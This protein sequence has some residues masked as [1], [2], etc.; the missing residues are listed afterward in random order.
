[1]L[2][3]EQKYLEPLVQ[4]LTT[5]GPPSVI[6]LRGISGSGKSILCNRL[7]ALLG[8]DKVS[9][10]SADDYFTDENG[11]YHFD[12]SKLP[13]AHAVCV[14]ALEDALVDPSIRVILVDRTHTRLWHMSN[15]EQVAK[16]HGARV[17]VLEIVVP[18]NAHFSLCYQRQRHN[19]PKDVLYDQWMGWEKYLGPCVR[20]PMFVSRQEMG[21]LNA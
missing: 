10:C 19:V 17:F 6:L 16:K 2:K 7:T 13:D 9:H 14:A 8:A 11:A 18:D 1:M 12:P 20:V 15:A 21:L 4:N 3:W 5:K